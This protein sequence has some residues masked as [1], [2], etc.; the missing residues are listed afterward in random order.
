MTWSTR[1]ANGTDPGR[2][3][4]TVEEAGVVD[5]PGGQVGQRPAA[6][7]VELD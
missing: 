2:L 7:V 1:R 3:L 5:V 6:Q 4:D